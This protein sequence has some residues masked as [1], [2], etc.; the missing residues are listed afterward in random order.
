MS[1]NVKE[2]LD[3]ITGFAMLIADNHINYTKEQKAEFYKHILKNTEQL[4]GVVN[5]VLKEA[6]KK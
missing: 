5:N 4:L 6:Q 2:L 3:S 1:C